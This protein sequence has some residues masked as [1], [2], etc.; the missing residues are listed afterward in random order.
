MK[1]PPLKKIPEKKVIVD[2]DYKT[3]ENGK[4]ER[5]VDPRPEFSVTEEVMPQIKDWVVGKKYRM[6]VEVE[7]V[8]S[9][10]EDWGDDK[11]KLKANFKISGIGEDSDEDEEEEFPEA[12]KKSKK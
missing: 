4:T 5:V 10:I 7:M 3:L 11:G 2:N 1:T 12:M 9:R 8:G 6:E